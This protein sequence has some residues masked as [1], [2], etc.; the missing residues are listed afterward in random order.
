MNESFDVIA[1][2]VCEDYIIYRCP[3]CYSKYKKDG[4]PYK[5]AKQVYHMHGNEE[6][7][8]ENRIIHRGHHAVSEMEGKSPPNVVI[9][10][11][12]NTLKLIPK[13]PKPRII[14]SKIFH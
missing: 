12:D 5:S 3:H 14:K 13:V 7:S 10:I 11:T 6:K 9:H 1:E 2:R 4:T 8:D